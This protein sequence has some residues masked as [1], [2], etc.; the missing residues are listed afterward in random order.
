[1]K[2]TISGVTSSAAQ[3]EVALVFARF[4]VGDDDE[5]PGPDV[6]DRLFYGAESHD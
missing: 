5:L 2:L 3:I 4:V 1:M 6:P